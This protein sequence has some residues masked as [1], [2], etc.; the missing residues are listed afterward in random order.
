MRNIQSVPNEIVPKNSS[1]EAI[2]IYIYIY[3]YT[4]IFSTNEKKNDQH[5]KDFDDKHWNNIAYIYNIWNDII[6][7][8]S[9][10]L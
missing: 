4:Y 9:V 3:I 10:C 1:Y 2:Y 7:E 6:W 8:E 5:V